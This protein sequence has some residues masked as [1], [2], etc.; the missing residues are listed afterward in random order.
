MSRLR[1]RFSLFEGRVFSKMS[2]FQNEK[3]REER[4]LLARDGIEPPPPAFSGMF[5][6]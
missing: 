5:D 6:Q 2:L 3:Q 1:A 4:A